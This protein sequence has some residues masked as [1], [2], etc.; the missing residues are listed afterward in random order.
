MALRLALPRLFLMKRSLTTC[1]CL[2]E[3]MDQEKFM[4]HTALKQ[5][6]DTELASKELF[7]DAKAKNKE[8]FKGVFILQD[9]F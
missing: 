1:P 9:I 6:R 4:K 3:K 5:I 2:L 7:E 8:T